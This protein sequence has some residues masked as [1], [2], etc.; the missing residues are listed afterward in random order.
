MCRIIVL[1][2]AIIFGTVPAGRTVGSAEPS[3]NSFGQT[4]ID[5]H[6]MRKQCQC[7]E[8]DLLL[9]TGVVHSA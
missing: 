7:G 1:I 5:L 3:Q 9:E 6:T 4:Y 2:R 8:V